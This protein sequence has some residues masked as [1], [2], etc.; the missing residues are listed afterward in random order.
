MMLE[1][2]CHRRGPGRIARF[3]YVLRDVPWDVPRDVRGDEPSRAKD[4]QKR[5]QLKG[6]FLQMERDR[7]VTGT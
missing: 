4:F 3:W 7:D 6:R 5:T 2:T 1:G